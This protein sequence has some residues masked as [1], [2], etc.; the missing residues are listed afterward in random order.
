MPRLRGGGM[1]TT[2]LCPA[3]GTQF[4]VVLG[5]FGQVAGQVEREAV[6][7]GPPRGGADASADEHRRMRAR[8]RSRGEVCGRPQRHQRFEEFV[9]Q[10]AAVLE[11]RCRTT[12]IRRAGNPARA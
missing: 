11:R 5:E 9:H 10:A 8:Q 4:A 1:T 2:G 6:P 12:R 7:G 3:L